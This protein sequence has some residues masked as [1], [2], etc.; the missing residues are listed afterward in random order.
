MKSEKLYRVMVRKTGSMQPCETFW[1][2]ETLYCGT[3]RTEARRV[4]H[5]SAPSD[6]GGSFGNACRETVCEVI[7]DGE[8]DDFA[9]DN[10]AK[11]E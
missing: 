6:F 7:T 5:E 10:L 2:R 3:D 9:G 4:Y 11:A 1:R 8:A